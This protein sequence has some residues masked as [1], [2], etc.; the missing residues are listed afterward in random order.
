VLNEPWWATH[1]TAIYI[2]GAG[3]S[4]AAGLPLADDLWREVYR[5]ALPMTG[6]ASQFCEDLDEYIE[7]KERCE[8]VRLARE[9]VNF[10]EFLGFLDIEH[11]LGA[12]DTWG[13]DGNE[14]QIIVKTLIGQILTE[15]M[16]SANTIPPLYLKFVEKLQP[17]DRII[18]FNY[19]ILLERACEVVGRP[20]RLAPGRYTHVRSNVYGGSATTDETSYDEITI[21]KLHG[22][23][24]WF[25]KKHYR[26]RQENARADGH[27]D[28]VPDDPIFNSPRNLRTI[29]RVG[30]PRFDDDPLREVH[31][32]LDIERFYADPPWFRATPTLIAPSTAK[33][34][35]SPRF[36][37]FWHGQGGSGAHNF[38]MVI[39]G[40]SLPAHDEYA[41]QF[42][43]RSVTN[44]QD[45]PGERIDPRRGEKEPLMF[46]DLCKKAAQR[47]ALRKR[48]RFIDWKRARTFLSGFNEDVIAAL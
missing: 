2:L 48:Y 43:Y 34:V 18:T 30:G 25:D 32:L 1:K 33:L 10:E 9:Q 23:I 7:F 29:P 37:E 4:A 5:R 39:I 42:I 11:Y 22:S 28:Y 13:E 45:I 14:S 17:Y 38:R 3:F 26:L 40:Y 31:R 12:K 8:G 35:Y 19:D 6:R 15:K 41:R 27:P 47:T 44:Y 16:P 21:L 36:A 46:V 20:F 24:D